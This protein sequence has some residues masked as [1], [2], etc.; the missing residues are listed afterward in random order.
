MKTRIAA[1]MLAL[2][3]ATSASAVTFSSTAGNPDPGPAAGQNIVFDFNS[4]TP[5]LS[6]SF[7]LVT[8]TAPGVYAAPAGDATQYAVVPMAGQGLGVATLDFSGIANV[9]TLSFYWGSIDTYNT[10][11]FLSGGTSI[12]TLNGAMLPPANG[13]Q[14]AGLTNR[15]VYFNFGPGETFDTIRFTSDGVAFEFDDIAVGVPE[16]AS[17][18]M[19]I[20]G[21]GMVGFAAR[22][23]NSRVVA[24]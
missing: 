12:F 19:M 15:R 5:E 23:R 11:E 13:D 8:G 22:R 7:S 24:A 10:I 4:P 6:G 18:A 20:M 2:A 21:F 1:A 14:G 9:K 3:V 17:W 16:P